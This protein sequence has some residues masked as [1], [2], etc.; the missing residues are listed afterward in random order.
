[1]VRVLEWT[2]R[3]D[4]RTLKGARML[5]SAHSLVGAKI[6][7]LD[8]D[9]GHIEDLY[10]DDTDWMIRY[11]IVRTGSWFSGK[12][13]LL[14]P[15]SVSQVK[16]DEDAVYMDLTQKQIKDSPDL[17]SALPVTREQELELARYYQWPAYWS[18]GALNVYNNTG[19]SLSMAPLGMPPME[20]P[21][22]DRSLGVPDE[23]ANDIS[24][25][26]ISNANLLGSDIANS[27]EGKVDAEVRR[28]AQAE[29]PQ[30]NLRALKKVTGYH[31]AAGD[32]E[33]GH[34]DDFLLDDADWKIE[35]LVV[36]TGNWLGGKKVLVAPAQVASTFWDDKRIRIAATRA[37][38]ESMPEYEG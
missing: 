33:I 13:I 6:H 19:T 27:A 34:V 29:E 15:A 20:V 22:G 30:H 23:I 37:Q 18:P 38:L 4:R 1:M 35:S 14:S 3:F 26:D 12:D 32:G 21:V 16:W 28:A 7:A 31:I 8:G 10:F 36:A 25:T 24:S 9:M 11:I 2:I 17:T 5:H